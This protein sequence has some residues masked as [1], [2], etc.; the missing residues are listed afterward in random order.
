M[1]QVYPTAAVY[2]GV[3]CSDVTQD[4]GPPMTM[5]GSFDSN[6]SPLVHATVPCF[7]STVFAAASHIAPDINLTHNVLR[8]YNRLAT[9]SLL[10]QAHALQ[11]DTPVFGVLLMKDIV[12][13]HIDWYE[14]CDGGVVGHLHLPSTRTYQPLSGMFFCVLSA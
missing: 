9:T 2:I 11:I 14:E 7:A 6:M 10:R 12:A 1:S 3:D 5:L 4:P 8:G 13:I